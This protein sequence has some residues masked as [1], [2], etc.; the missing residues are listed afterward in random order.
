MD[1]FALPDDDLLQALE[2][3]HLYRNFMGYTERKHKPLIG[4]GVS[5]ISESSSFYMQNFKDIESYYRAI[6]KNELPM[7]KCL[8]NSIQYAIITFI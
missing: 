2:H 3:K 7:K 4:L 8:H 5:A 6:K 1:H